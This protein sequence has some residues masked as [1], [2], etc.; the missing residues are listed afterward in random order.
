MGNQFSRGN[1]VF[2]PN[3]TQ[4]PTHT[5]GDA[6][7]EFLLGDL[8]QSTVAVAIASAN[9]QRNTEAAFVDDTYNIT[10][11]V[12][13]SLGLRYELTPPW[14][15]QL[16]NDFTVALPALYFG[17]Q[18]PQS[19]WPYFVRQGNCTDPYQG[20]AINWTDTTGVAGTH[21]SPAPVCS[22]GAY[23]D[24]LM[25]TD[26]RNWAPRLGV[27]WSPDTKL[28]VRAGF[29]VFYNQDIGNAVFRYG[30]QYRRTRHADLRTERRHRGSAE[31]VL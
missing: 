18:A 25:Q 9:Y 23:P 11:Q 13:L 15:D 28:V 26:Y 16:G 12:T 14:V 30:A 2:Q 19:Q 1:F 17:P 29:G 3:A 31:S 21:A 7:A 4:S 20:L 22:N 27:S 24:A 5:G 10:P 8:Y 6:F